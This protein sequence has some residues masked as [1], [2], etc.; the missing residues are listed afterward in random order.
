MS[1]AATNLPPATPP[2][3]PAAS[4]ATPPAAPAA[5]AATPPAAPVSWY[6]GA[7]ADLTGWVQ[8][9]GFKTPIDALESA[10]NLE[11]LMG[12]PPERILKLADKMRGDD[13]KLTAEGRQIFERLGA[14]KEAKDYQ[15]DIPKEFG[16]AKMAETFQGLFH[17]EG[18]AKAS[19]ER[20]VKQWNE[21]QNAQRTAMTEAQKEADRQAEQVLKRDWGQAY[22]QNTNIAKEAVRTLGLDEKSLNSLSRSLGHDKTMKL[23]QKLGASV[24]EGRFVQG[25]S[26]NTVLEPSQAQYQIK[27][28]MKDRDFAGRLAKGDSE[29]LSKWTRLHEMAAPGQFS[30]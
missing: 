18:V 26:A 15:I 5:S 25:G 12:A 19:A 8:N 3:A 4:A 16:D 17:E 9:K 27:E 7:S 21:Y 11:K 10:R 30:T 2:A 13:G 6:E 24:G 1:E 14:P 28:L 22:E 23:L 20:I 29:A